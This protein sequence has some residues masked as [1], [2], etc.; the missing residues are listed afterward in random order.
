[1]RVRF[2]VSPCST[3][4]G[5]P[6]LVMLSAVKPHP[7]FTKEPYNVK[8]RVVAAPALGICVVT[9]ATKKIVKT[10]A[11]NHL[12]FNPS[13]LSNCPITP[14]YIAETVFTTL[15]KDYSLLYANKFFL[16][17]SDVI[18]AVNH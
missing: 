13:T 7:P 18:V 1:M 8:L 2:T 6:G 12:L 17:A 14:V 10:V 3:T 15:Q 9:N 4:I 5:G 16:F 11:K